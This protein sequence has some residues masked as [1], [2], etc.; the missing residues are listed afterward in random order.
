MTDAE[1]MQL[2]LIKYIERFNSRVKN[3]ILDFTDRV[4]REGLSPR[5]P[6]FEA[7]GAAMLGSCILAGVTEGRFRVVFAEPEAK[8]GEG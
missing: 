4:E 7:Y 1:S 3:G 5:H 6:D 8:G 2:R